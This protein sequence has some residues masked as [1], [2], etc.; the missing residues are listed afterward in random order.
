MTVLNWLPSSTETVFVANGLPPG[1]TEGCQVAGHLGVVNSACFC[2]FP[3]RHA[4]QVEGRDAAAAFE[5]ECTFASFLGNHF[6]APDHVRGRLSRPGDHIPGPACL[7]CRTQNR[8][9]SIASS[10]STPSRR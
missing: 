2:D 7:L 10:S 5:D 3:L 4:L 9:S 8:V 1:H 6:G